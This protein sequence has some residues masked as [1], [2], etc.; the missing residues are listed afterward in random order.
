M[1]IRQFINSGKVVSEVT[2]IKRVSCVTVGFINKH[3]EEDETQ[4]TVCQDIRTIS[5]SYELEELF[6]SQAADLGACKTKIT[7]IVVVASA[8]TYQELI[9]MG[10]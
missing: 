4:L 1:T 6:N 3:K 10:Y 9:N 5:G 7:S 2:E 8:D